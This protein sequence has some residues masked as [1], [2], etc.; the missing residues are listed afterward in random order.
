MAALLHARGLRKDDVI[1]SQLPNCVELHAL[2]LACAC[3]GIVLSPVPVQ[4]AHEYFTDATGQLNI[5][6]WDTTGYHRKLIDFPRHELMC[7]LEGAVEFEDDTGVRQRFQEAISEK[8][9]VFDE[10]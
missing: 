7:L 3:T 4:H 6:V 2:Y 9:Q 5:G 10:R 8:M 1:V